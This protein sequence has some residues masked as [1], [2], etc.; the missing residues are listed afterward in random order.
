MFQ[1]NNQFFACVYKHV[2]T[3]DFCFDD[4]ESKGNE[5]FTYPN[6]VPHG[7]ISFV[8]IASNDKRFKLPILDEKMF[9]T[10]KDK[11]PK[12]LDIEFKLNC[13]KENYMI[14]VVNKNNIVNIIGV[15]Y[16]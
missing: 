9:L 8:A 1:N 12:S 5:Y 15:Y 11:Y 10:I 6:N 3:N 14:P 13:S 4:I 16:E 7:K 2:K